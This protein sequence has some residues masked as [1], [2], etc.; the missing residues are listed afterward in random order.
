MDRR[1][2][3]SGVTLGLLAAPLAAGAQQ[4]GKVFRIGVLYPG[5][6]NSIFRNNFNGFRQ[7]LGPAGYVEGRNLTV[8]VRVG[9]GRALA[10]LA[11]ELMTRHPDLI[12]AV[13][14]PGVLAMHTVGATIPVVALDLES[15]PVASRFVKTVP[16]PGG[17]ITGVF[18]DFPELAGKWLEILKTT[19][20]RLARVA[21]LWD[22]STGPAQL[23]AASQAAQSLKLAMYTVEARSTGEIEPAFR[24]AMRERP[25][26][27]VVLTS[28]IFNS[29][30]R[31]IGKLAARHRLPTLV[32]FPGYAADGGLVSY[33]PDVMT[34]YAQA[35]RS[36]RRSCSGRIR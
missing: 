27:M 21:V 4:T 12:V 13:A 30:R 15:D 20:P 22:P 5:A 16:R 35:G 36:R 7:V 9:D 34:M 3:V 25:T 11:A 6:D 28:P 17:N 19:V 32:P 18:M 8:D 31:E 33:G 10:P 23:D 14:R 1:T 2:F 26:G 24:A 29:G